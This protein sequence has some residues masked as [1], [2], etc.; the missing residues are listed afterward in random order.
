[1]IYTF[2]LKHIPILSSLNR[3]NTSFYSGLC[4]KVQLN[5]SQVRYY[6]LLI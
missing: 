1:M 3:M 4:L 6:Q 2:Y 5:I